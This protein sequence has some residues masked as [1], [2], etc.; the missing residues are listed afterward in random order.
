MVICQLSTASDSDSPSP[1]RD[2]LGTCIRGV[3]GHMQALATIAVS[4][5]LPTTSISHHS[6]DSRFKVRPDVHA[7][8]KREFRF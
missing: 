4:Q 8:S 2:R 7:V 3:R 6:V 5:S 1:P